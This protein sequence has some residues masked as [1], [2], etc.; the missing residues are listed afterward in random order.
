MYTSC[1]SILVK[2]SIYL[3]NFNT[4][5][6]LVALYYQKRY[7]KI[8]GGNACTIF[9]LL[10]GLCFGELKIGLVHLHISAAMTVALQGLPN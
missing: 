10:C 7:L 5:V 9:S 8:F 3:G 2:V 6:L 1:L 4:D